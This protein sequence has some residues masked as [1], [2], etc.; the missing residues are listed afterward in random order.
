VFDKSGGKRLVFCG[1]FCGGS[2]VGLWFLDG[3]FS[4]LKIFLSGKIFSVEN[5]V[6]C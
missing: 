6:G 4:D 2:M 1:D 3:A 5:V